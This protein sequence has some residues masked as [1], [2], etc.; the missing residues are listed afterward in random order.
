MSDKTCANVLMRSR[1]N[2]LHSLTKKQVPALLRSSADYSA[3]SLVPVITGTK[4]NV[5]YG[6]LMNV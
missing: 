4:L 2:L 6:T 5:P 3:L 1:I